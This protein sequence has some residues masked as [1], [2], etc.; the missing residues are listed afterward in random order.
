MINAWTGHPHF[1][2]IDNHHGGGFKGKIAAL[3]RAVEKYVGLP[4]M[5][6][7][8]R[9]FLLSHDGEGRFI[10]DEPADLKRE[11][12]EVE[13]IFL[14]N[15]HKNML[16]NK[17]RSR[18][19]EDSYTYI[20]ETRSIVKGEE[21]I[22]KRQITAREFVQLG[23]QRDVNKKPIEKLRHCFIFKNQNF[24]VDVFQNTK[25]TPV[26]LRIETNDKDEHINLPPFVDTVREVTGE[27]IY[28]TNVM[29]TKEYEM[30]S[31]DIEKTTMSNN[32]LAKRNSVSLSNL[33]P[34]QK[35]I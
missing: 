28:S 26:V 12:F 17:I 13:E 30:P 20:H 11:T 35:N 3:I 22:M 19:K 14:V 15:S 23:D 16:E 32:V 29:S 6:H 31:E 2:I 21:I 27:S 24:V 5:A 9:K 4:E 7:V 10:V 25:G 8:Q 33:N 34:D 1:K 18:G